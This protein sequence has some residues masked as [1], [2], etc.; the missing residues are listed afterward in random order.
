VKTRIFFLVVALLALYVIVHLIVLR[1]GNIARVDKQ[2]AAIEFRVRDSQSQKL[3]LIQEKNNL[4]TAL[5]SIPETIREG[6]S[7]P[8]REFVQFMNYINKSELSQM[9]GSVAISDMQ[10]F[11]TSPVPLQETQFEFEFEM[12]STQQL[13]KFLDYFLKKWKY[14]LDVQHLEIKRVSGHYPHVFLKVGLLLPAK[15]DLPRFTQKGK[16]A[17]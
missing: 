12:K 14:P 10:T 13:E 2:N 9:Q 7:D 5:E 6:S 3:N 15:I 16:E 4:A 11:K 17:S 1:K 8:E